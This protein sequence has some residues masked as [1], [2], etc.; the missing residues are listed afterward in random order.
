MRRTAHSPAEIQKP[1]GNGF[2]DG[3][4]SNFGGLTAGGVL[5]DLWE[6]KLGP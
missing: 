3:H 4:P 5:G 2:D 6:F 1:T